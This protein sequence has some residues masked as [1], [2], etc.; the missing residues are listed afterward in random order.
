MKRRSTAIRLLLILVLATQL[1]IFTPTTNAG[2][3][4]SKCT[5]TLTLT[6]GALT[7]VKA[8]SFFVFGSPATFSFSYSAV[9]QGITYSASASG[10]CVR[11]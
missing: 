5:G 10:T 4:T 7:V 1:T 8:I 2:F 9:I 11:N 3:T 6:A